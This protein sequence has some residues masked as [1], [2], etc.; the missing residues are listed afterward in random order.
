[1]MAA[2]SSA[3]PAFKPTYL[4]ADELPWHPFTP[5]SEEVMLKILHLD[6]VRGEV[7]LLLKAPG[8]TNLGVHN[9]YGRVLVYTVQGT[10]RYAEHDWTSSAG[11]FVYEVANSSH[12]F[13]AQPG[14]DVIV[15]IV[16][17]GALAFLDENGN[18][19]AVETAQ[20]VAERYRAY[21]GANGI[22]EVDLTAFSLT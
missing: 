16:L 18:T 15:F 12:T 7:V 1:P 22:P 14:D 21:C 19:V 5:Y 20:T 2:I 17:E 6:M 4:G 13:Q 9:H 8:G 3:M 10:W 11:D